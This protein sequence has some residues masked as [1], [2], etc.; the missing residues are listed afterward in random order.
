MYILY[1]SLLLFRNC[2]HFLISIYFV[3]F[4]QKGVAT[5]NV[6][7][8]SIHAI[9][10]VPYLAKYSLQMQME[11]KLTQITAYHISHPVNNDCLL[12]LSLHANIYSYCPYVLVKDEIL[13]AH[14]I[15][16]IKYG[17]QD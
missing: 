7:I 16:P 15:S 3:L 5:F 14:K 11:S 12:I 17:V 8:C 4:A 13:K 9:K 6:Y 10:T 2:L 1:G